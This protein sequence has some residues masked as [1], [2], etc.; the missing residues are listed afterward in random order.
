V[1]RVVILLVLTN[2]LLAIRVEMLEMLTT[3]VLAL[4]DVTFKLLK[5]P[6]EAYIFDPVRFCMVTLEIVAVVAVKLVTSKSSVFI[7]SASTWE[8]PKRD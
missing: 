7:L 1:V 6:D 3:S 8:R 5:N 2:S 4:R